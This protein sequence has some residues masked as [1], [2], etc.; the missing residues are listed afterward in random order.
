M[1]RPDELG[2]TGKVA[3]RP[4]RGVEGG[5]VGVPPLAPGERRL[6]LG[7]RRAR[8][9]APLSFHAWLSERARGRVRVRVRAR[10]RVRVRV[11]VRVRIR[12]RSYP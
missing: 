4:G 6:R 9:R 5:E 3:P 7:R 12:V 11:R 1:R 2:G 8:R 10:A